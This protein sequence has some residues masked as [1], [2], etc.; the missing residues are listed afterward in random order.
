MA[1]GYEM[2]DEI[3]MGEREAQMFTA[4]S[5][6]KG[7]FYAGEMRGRRVML[8][9]TEIRNGFRQA[10]TGYDQGFYTHLMS[11]LRDERPT[12]IDMITYNKLAGK[13]RG[14]SAALMREERLAEKQRMEKEGGFGFSFSDAGAGLGFG[15]AAGGVGLSSLM[16]HGNEK[17]PEIDRVNRQ[18]SVYTHNIYSNLL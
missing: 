15:L 18:G 4:Y 17:D 7:L 11:R 2:L 16:R 9:P 10:T 13:S 3:L 12:E 8:T 6:K 14:K 5:R 1:E